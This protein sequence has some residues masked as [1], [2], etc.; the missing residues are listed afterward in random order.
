MKLNNTHL[1]L[2]TTIVLLG[3]CTTPARAP[4]AGVDLD[5]QRTALRAAADSY[6]AAAQS[7]NFDTVQSLYTS[8]ARIFPPNAP[9]ESGT[10]GVENFIDAFSSLPAFEASFDSP[11]VALGPDGGMGFTIA[12]ATLSFEGPDG[13]IVRNT[14]RDLHIWRREADGQWKVVVDMWNSATPAPADEE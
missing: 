13:E 5:A 8:D 6:H 14:F 12:A 2:C 11:M 7:S 4:D 9:E 1:L 10:A 3:S